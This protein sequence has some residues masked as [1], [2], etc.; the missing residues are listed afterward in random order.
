MVILPCAIACGLAVGTPLLAHRLLA[1]DVASGRWASWVGTVLQAVA[2]VSHAILNG[3]LLAAFAASLLPGREALATRLARRLQSSPLPGSVALYTR[4]VTQA[5]CLFFAG[6]LVASAALLA[7]APRP[8]WSLFVGVLDL[9]L[10][11]LMFAGEY[12]CRVRLV[13][14]EYR[15]GPVAT[16]LAFA[17]HGAGG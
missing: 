1:G 5:W 13:A 6:Q 7:W 14:R 4:R 16:V 2:G 12:A 3:G 8:V 15:P 17:R 11:V 9:P 10:V